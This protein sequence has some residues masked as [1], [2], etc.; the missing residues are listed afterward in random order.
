[1]TARTHDMIAFAALITVAG[2]Y[3]P[4][5]LN[6]ATAFIC[7]IG[8]VVGALAPDLDQATNRLWDLLPAGNFVGKLLRNLLLQHRTI[9]HSLF[10]VWIMFQLL[11]FILPKILNPESVNIHLVV[12]SIM[13]GF[14][15]HLVADMLTKDGIPLFFPL[16]FKIGLPPVE[17]LRISTG[18]FMEKFVV[19]PATVVYLIWFISKNNG[20][21][22]QLL[23]KIY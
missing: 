8:S 21:L 5:Q 14:I 23:K 12:I 22:L 19:F 2:Y 7:L 20:Q 4:G 18:K 1:M 10:G 13:V 17:W 9:S 6:V 16:P 11:Y 15:S 3:P